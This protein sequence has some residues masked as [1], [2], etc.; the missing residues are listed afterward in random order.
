MTVVGYGCMVFAHCYMVAVYKQ[1]I[2]TSSKLRKAVKSLVGSSARTRRWMT[3]MVMKRV[4]WI[5]R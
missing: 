4:K 5:V 3:T 1:V 2:F